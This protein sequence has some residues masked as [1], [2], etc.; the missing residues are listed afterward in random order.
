MR[1]QVALLLGVLATLTTLFIVAHG[2][3]EAPDFT[4]AYGRVSAVRWYWVVTVAYFAGCLVQL[5]KLTV[6]YA[7]F[8]RRRQVR[9]GFT[10]VA[11]GVII[12]GVYSILKMIEVF[13]GTLSGIVDQLDHVALTAGAICIGAGLLYP[14]AA[15][16]GSRTL[17]SLRARFLLLR[18]RTVW[19]RTVKVCPD[20]VLGRPP[21]FYQ[22]ALGRD[23]HFRLY[24]RVVETR[25]GLFQRHLKVDRETSDRLDLATSVSRRTRVRSRELR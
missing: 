7:R 2:G 24:R 9:H 6:L 8:S 20:V 13:L 22:D 16:S 5:A 12:G 18:L 21:T 11:A 3:A 19:R 14:V 23:P 15:A 10:A 1:R 4:A 25:D 17:L